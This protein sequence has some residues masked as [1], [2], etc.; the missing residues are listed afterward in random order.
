MKKN[1]LYPV[2]PCHR[3]VRSDGRFG[4]EEERAKTRRE[5]VEKE[6]TSIENGRIK[7]SED[8]LF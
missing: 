6:G 4:G 3:I 8:I 5:L 1:P 7:I 2:V